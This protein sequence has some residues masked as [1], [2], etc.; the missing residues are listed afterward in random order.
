M[1]VKEVVE[2]LSEMNPEN[3]IWIT[4]LTKDDVLDN[5]LEQEVLDSKGNQVD[6]EQY[7]T[8]NAL[9]TIGQSLDNDEHLWQV[10]NEAVSEYCNDRLFCLVKEAEVDEELWDKEIT[11]ES[12]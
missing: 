3:E 11:N 9:R 10:F 2:L 7:V 12:K 4:Y 8:D 5:F 6:T 1:K